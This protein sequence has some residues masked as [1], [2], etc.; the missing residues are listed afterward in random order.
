MFASEAQRHL[1]IVRR[2]KYFKFLRFL[3]VSRQ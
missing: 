2:G 1:R 3:A